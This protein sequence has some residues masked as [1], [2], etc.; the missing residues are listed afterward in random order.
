VGRSGREGKRKCRPT[1][2]SKNRCLY[3]F[4]TTVTL[5]ITW[6]ANPAVEL[7]STPWITAFRWN[8]QPFSGVRGQC[9]RLRTT[10][11][12]KTAAVVSENIW[13][14]FATHGSGH[15]NELTFQRLWNR[16]RNWTDAGIQ[17]EFFFIAVQFRCIC[18][19]QKASLRLKKN[20]SL[21]WCLYV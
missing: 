3:K 15:A 11:V 9:T 5:N 19:S 13:T 17:Q 16:L 10:I 14:S 12:Q 2:I 1:V 7:E 18:Y 8:R 21:L 6:W 20:S 4:Y